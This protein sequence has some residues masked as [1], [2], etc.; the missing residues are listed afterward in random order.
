VPSSTF[1]SDSRGAKRAIGWVAAWLVAAIATVQLVNPAP[2]ILTGSKGSMAQY[3]SL[4][5]Q[6]RRGQHFDW[7]AIGN[8]FT[9]Q[10]VDPRVVREAMR[11]RSGRDL[12]G[13][14][15]ASGGIVANMLERTVALAYGVQRPAACVLVVTPLML[16][17]EGHT[18]AERVEV[19]GASPYGRVLADPV[20]WRRALRRTL[21][22]SV[23]IAGMRYAWKDGLLG[24][25][26]WSW[27]PVP[28][29][30][31]AGFTPLAK[32]PKWD[33]PN[34]WRRLG[35]FFDGGLEP[36]RAISLLVGAIEEAHAQ[37][38]QQVIV[39]EGAI[40]PRTREHL[41]AAHASRAE[42]RAILTEAA[43]R[44]KAQLL[45]LEDGPSFPA[46]IFRDPQHF[47]ERGA[48]R[49]SRWLG[50]SLP[51]EAPGA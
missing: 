7:I 51:L 11:E 31:R 21:L 32:D 26:I 2:P 43:E 39:V 5:T 38:A 16:F 12:S 35:R 4:R 6:T 37:G 23:A 27:E 33:T 28:D 19:F 47:D 20:P 15:F 24:K 13:Y 14:N 10:G 49:Y 46:E 41:E 34:R 9:R 42:I 8:S 18:V 44:G 36:E 48:E 30:G 3:E 1:S 50:H 25:A 29:D 17:T 40:H 22:D 45:L